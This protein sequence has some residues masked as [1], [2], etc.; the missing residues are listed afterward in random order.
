[1][2]KVAPGGR[3]TR[4]KSAKVGPN[5]AK[6]AKVGRTRAE[7]PE[8]SFLPGR[9]PAAGEEIEGVPVVRWLPQ[10]FVAECAGVTTRQ[11]QNLEKRGLPHAGYAATKMYPAPHFVIWLTQWRKA[12]GR[13]T[14][15]KFAGGDNLPFAVALARHNLFWREFE[16]GL[17]DLHGRPVRS[18]TSR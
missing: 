14:E 16:S 17:V 15:G 2:K 6:P 8:M 11:L 13:N 4:T 3:K 12:R 7:S 10:A 5:R 9:E 18:G 1:M